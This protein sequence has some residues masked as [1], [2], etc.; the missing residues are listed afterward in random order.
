MG[1]FHM[2]RTVTLSMMNGGVNHKDRR[3]KPLLDTDGKDNKRRVQ[4]VFAQK[5]K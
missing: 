5:A 1:V 4:Y 3:G 2:Y